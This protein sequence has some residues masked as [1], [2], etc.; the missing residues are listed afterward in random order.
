MSLPAIIAFFA[1]LVLIEIRTISYAVWNWK[2]DNKFGSFM[3]LLLCI[4]ATV[5]P[6][7]TAFFKS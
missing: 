2:N 7:Y 4:S 3:V 1:V 5:M 6:V